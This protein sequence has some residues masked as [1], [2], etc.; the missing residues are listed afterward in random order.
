MRQVEDRAQNIRRMQLQAQTQPPSDLR[1]EHI[2]SEGKDR[3]D[4]QGYRQR[5]QRRR[6]MEAEEESSDDDYAG[7][8]EPVDNKAE[9]EKNAEIRRCR[10]ILKRHEENLRKK[11]EKRKLALEESTQRPEG[12]ISKAPRPGPSQERW[13]QEARRLQP[14]LPPAISITREALYRFSPP[15]AFREREE[16]PG[17]RKREGYSVNPWK[18]F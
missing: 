12:P 13:H 11:R 16:Y 3:I 7:D 4:S 18:T 10:A 14:Q 9:E 1:E 15:P 2:T 8:E 17:I 5:A 6:Q